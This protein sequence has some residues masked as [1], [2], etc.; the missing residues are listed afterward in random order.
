MNPYTSTIA[1]QTMQEDMYGA[2]PVMDNSARQKTQDALNQQGSRIAQDA[3][4]VNKDATRGVNPFLLAQA[5]RSGPSSGPVDLPK[6]NLPPVMG[7]AGMGDSMGTGLLP[8]QGTK[9]GE[10]TYS[11]TPNPNYMNNPTFGLKY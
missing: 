10:M 8:N 3:L 2:P 5:L 9:F 6:S 7:V 4:N 11:G 1:P